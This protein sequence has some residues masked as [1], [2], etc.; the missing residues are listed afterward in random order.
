MNMQTPDRKLRIDVPGNRTQG[1]LLW[2]DLI[3]YRNKKALKNH[4]NYLSDL[5]VFNSYV[6]SYNLLIAE[7]LINISQISNH[8]IPGADK[9]ELSV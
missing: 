1:L 5:D 8:S 2:D 4:L 7:R 6:N 3:K 9:P